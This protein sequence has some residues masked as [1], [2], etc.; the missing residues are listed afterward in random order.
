M[1][2][3]R[4]RRRLRQIDVAMKAGCG[5]S[6]ISLIERGHLERLSIR[7]V[8]TV[9]A[10]LDARF[11]GLV[12]WRGGDVDRL[13]DSRHAA[14]VEDAAG[15][16][17]QL[18]WD[19][20]VEVSYAR[21]GERGSIDLLAAR[22]ERRAV[23]VMEMKSEITAIEELAR[24]HD[25]K[26]RLAGEICHERFGW[27][28]LHVARLLVVPEDRTIRRVIARYRATF[29]AAYPMAN[30]EL[31]RWLA[32]PSGPASGVW[33]LPLNNGGGASRGT[34]RRRTANGGGSRS[35]GGGK[36]VNPGQTATP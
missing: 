4:R 5:Q 29:G 33:F 27:R 3:I 30:V 15:R 24:R 28:P 2:A 32:A 18:G 25:E 1:R 9:A 17:R 8:R 21:Y 31:R 35:A 6:T 11:D 20:H 19:V 23:A 12:S 34:V 16:L 13:T 36:P 26:T 10:A 7:R 22:Q 14:L